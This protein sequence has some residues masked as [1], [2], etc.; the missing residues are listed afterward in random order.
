MSPWN[1]RLKLY[2]QVHVSQVVR[3]LQ[4]IDKTETILG[5]KKRF[6]LENPFIPEKALVKSFES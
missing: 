4:E 1:I 3:L 5:I 2:F 6:A